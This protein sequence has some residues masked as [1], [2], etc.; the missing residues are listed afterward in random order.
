MSKSALAF[1]LA[2]SLV[3]LWGGVPAFAQKLPSSLLE[4]R[5]IDDD[6][7]RLEC[8]DDAMAEIDETLLSGSAA[9]EESADQLAAAGPALSAEERFGRDDLPE[10]KEKR[11]EKEEKELKSLTAKIA[12]IAQNRRG[13]YVIILENGQVWRQLN[14]DTNSLLIPSSDDEALSAEIKR[15]FLGAHVLSLVGDNRSIRVERIK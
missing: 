10:T 4:C 15:R 14:A 5:D 7:D 12:E 11:R 3:L 6:S 1:R 8:F 2:F 13:K 9:P